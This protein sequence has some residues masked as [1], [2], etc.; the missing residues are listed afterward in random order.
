MG[1]GRNGVNVGDVAVGVAQGLQ[2]DSLGVGLDG[3][4]HPGKVVGVDKGGGDAEGRQGVGQ[5]VEAAAVDGLLGHD[6]VPCLGQSLNGVGDGR[7]AGGSGQGRYTA[8]QSRDPLF[9]HILGGVGQ[10]AID[11]ACVLQSEACGGVGAV[12]EHIG[13]GLVNGHGPG[14][15]S[16]VGLFLAY[17][18]LQSLKMIAAHK[19]YLFHI[20]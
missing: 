13:G 10:A 15:S 19:K 17:V 11:V 6:V 18:K 4:L 14:I 5:Q 2:I 12:A 16:G 8:L 9:Q 3:V 7:R 20:F 1:D